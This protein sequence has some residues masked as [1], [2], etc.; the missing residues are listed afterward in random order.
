MHERDFD[1]DGLLSPTEAKGPLSGGPFFR[2]QSAGMDILRNLLSGQA[3]ASS[4]EYALILA[5]IGTGISAAAFALGVDISFS[6]Q[7][8]GDIIAN[9]GGAC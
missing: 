8:S 5:I 9:C 1:D 4:A 7:R 2:W 3:G 6:L